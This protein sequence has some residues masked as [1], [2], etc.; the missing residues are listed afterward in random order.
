MLSCFSHVWLFA[1]IHYSVPKSL[2]PWD[3]P[4]KNSGV[5]SH[6]PL[7]GIFPTQG[8]NL[9]LLHWQAGSLPLVTPGKPLFRATIMEKDNISE[10]KN[11]LNLRENHVCNEFFFS[12]KSNELVVTFSWWHH[13]HPVNWSS[14]PLSSELKLLRAFT[15][16]PW[17]SLVA[18]WN[19]FVFPWG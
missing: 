6:F 19:Q 9:G 15:V 18:K 3:S 13:S 14:T 17:A 7:Q 5:D 4:H 12:I 8:M 10:V 1:T 2:C 11:H 16:F